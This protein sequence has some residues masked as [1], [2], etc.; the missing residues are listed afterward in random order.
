[1]TEPEERIYCRLVA[2]RAPDEFSL[3]LDRFSKSVGRSR[4]QVARY[5]IG[6]CLSAYEGDEGAIAKIRQ[7]LY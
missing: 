7:E 4:S 5:L 2:F 6:Q 3:R 1:M